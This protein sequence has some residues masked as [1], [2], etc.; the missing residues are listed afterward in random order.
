MYRPNNRYTEHIRYVRKSSG[1]SVF[2]TCSVSTGHSKERIG[3]PEM[4]TSIKGKLE[5]KYSSRPT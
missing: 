2:P 1:D 3:K 5:N 4:N